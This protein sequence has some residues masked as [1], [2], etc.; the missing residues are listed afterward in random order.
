MNYTDLGKFNAVEAPIINMAIAGIGT[1]CKA[2]D[3]V[4]LQKTCTFC[5]YNDL[6]K[7]R[8]LMG[9]MCRNMKAQK[10]ARN[11]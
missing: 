11:N 9:E 5:V 7:C 8:D 10:N 1:T 4:K 3:N 2:S 6:N